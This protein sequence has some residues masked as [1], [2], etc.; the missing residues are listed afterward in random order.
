VIR[1]LEVLELTGQPFS[2]SMPTREFRSPTVLLG[3]R[4]ERDE[5]D[6][7]IARRVD[8]MWARGLRRETEALLGEG[9][10]HGVTASRAIGYS[11][12]IAVIDGDLD[13]QVARADT[14]RATRRYARRQESWFRPDPRVVWLDALAPDLLDRALAAVGEGAAKGPAGIPENG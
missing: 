12:A 11:Q 4:L 6:R 10:R 14:A 9:L 2:A 8:L 5:L 1:A 3:L 7:R 13:E